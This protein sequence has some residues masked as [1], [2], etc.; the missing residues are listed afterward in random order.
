MS[1]IVAICLLK[2]KAGNRCWCLS[3]NGSIGAGTY[4]APRR[5]HLADPVL[6]LGLGVLLLATVVVNNWVANISIGVVALLLKSVH[7]WWAI[8]LLF[9]LRGRG[10]GRLV[11]CSLKLLELVSVILATRH[12]DQSQFSLLSL[13][14]LFGS[15]CSRLFLII[16]ILNHC[17]YLCW[18]L[19]VLLLVLIGK[20]FLFD[21]VIE[22]VGCGRVGRRWSY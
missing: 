18:W 6:Q 15:R 4:K 20:L 10:R 11:V 22:T 17:C 7:A 19:L 14:F 21:N 13:L 12:L 5:A 16:L 9:I 1:I 8:I 2:F 3:A